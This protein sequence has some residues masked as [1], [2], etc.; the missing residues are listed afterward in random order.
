MR[1]RILVAIALSSQ[2]SLLIA[3][4]PTTALDVTIQREIMDLI[5]LIRDRFR[6]AILLVTHDLG[7]VAELCDRVYVM[8]AGKIVEHGDVRSVMSRPQHPYTRALL[9]S[10]RSIDEYHETLYALEGGVPSLIDPPVGC[11]FRSRC[12]EA[13]DRCV[14]DP[15]LFATPEGSVSRCWLHA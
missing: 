12:P 2:P 3:D 13:F 1:Q 15:P 10:A 8:Y 6:T 5:G 9:R 4:E 11:R 14:E 7:I